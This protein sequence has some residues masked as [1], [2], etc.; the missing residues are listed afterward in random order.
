LLLDYIDWADVVHVH[1]P[2]VPIFFWKLPKNKKYIFTHHASLGR[3]ITN[4][5]SIVYKSFRYRSISTYVSKSAESNALSLNSEPVLIPNMIKI[6]PNISFNKRQGYLFIGRQESRKNYSFFV[7]LSNHKQFTNKLFYAITNK[8]KSDKNITIYENP[9]DEFKIEI[10]GKTN[11]YLALNTKS[12]SFGI[13]LL[14]AVNNGNLVISSDLI[15]FINVLPNS[16]IVYKNNNFDSLCNVLTKL[17][18]EDLNLLW[19]KQYKDI[20]EY[21]LEENMKKFILLY[22]NL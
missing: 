20:R 7:K 10:F 15:S 11:I 5:L 1:E 14:E 8:D 22:S 21:D 12:E 2:F 13:T 18:S 3:I 6:N 17:D 4:I 9:T 19:N 16:H